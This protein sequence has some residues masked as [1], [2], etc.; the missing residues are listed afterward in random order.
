MPIKSAQLAALLTLA[1]CVLGVVGDAFFGSNHAWGR[2]ENI[3]NFPV[4]IALELAGPGHGASQ[5]IFPFIFCL[6]FY[7]VVFWFVI[8]A[9]LRA[10]NS[11]K[12]SHHT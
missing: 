1:F 8:F 3:L 6:I 4:G 2:V 10:R 12:S 9:F 7:F 11:T 5:L